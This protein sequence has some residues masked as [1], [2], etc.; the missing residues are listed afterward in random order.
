MGRRSG[1]RAARV[2]LRE[3]PLAKDARAIWPGIEG[4]KF[5]PLTEKEC[6]EVF[7]AALTMLEDIGMG[8]ATPEFIEVVT[9]AGGR[10]DEHERLR[11]PRDLVLRCMDLAAKEIT[12]HSFNSDEGIELGG[13]KV[14]FSTAGAAVLMLDHETERFRHSTIRDV[15]DTARLADTLDNIHMFVRMVVARDMELSRDVDINTAYATMIGTSKPQGTSMFEPG[16]VH[17]IAAMYDMALGGEGEY[18]KRPF[19]M[20][21]NTFV[22]PPMRFAH[23]SALCMAE[24]VRVGMPINLLSAGQAGATSPAALAG[25]LVQALAECL[26]ALTCVNLIEPGHPCIMGL[27]PFVS[28][29]RTGAMSGGSGEEAILNAAAAQVAGSYLGLPV[30]VAAGMADS[31]LPDNQAGHEKG[32]AISLAANAG[33]NIVYESAGMLASLM[34]CSLEAM[35]IDNDMLGAINRTV[36]GIDITPDS[37]S[38]EAMRDVVYGA[39]HFLGHEQ[40]LSIMQSE[41]TYP[42]VGDRNSPDDWV[43]AGGKDVREV[44]HDYVTRTLERHWPD[45]V[46]ASNDAKIRAAFDNIALPPRP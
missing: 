43:D 20:A 37:L 1:G 6:S 41:Y 27:W 3:A 8:Q 35:V 19:V 30:G 38:T 31:K 10:M 45:H 44:A 23:D 14:H 32:L 25:S 17:E 11:F 5:R 34:A 29:L 26:A 15:Y 16:H 12:L 40:T 4:G 46:S 33:A 13:N 7:E 24:Q 18:R 9:A 21:N 39:G 36:R 2:A 22:V 42:M 28:D